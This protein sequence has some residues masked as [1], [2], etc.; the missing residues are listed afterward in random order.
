MLSPNE[1][2]LRRIAVPDRDKVEPDKPPETGQPVED[3]YPTQIP[4]PRGLV[5][6]AATEAAK[7]VH[8]VRKFKDR[9]EEAEYREELRRRTGVPFEPHERGLV[10]VKEAEMLSRV[11]LNSR[12]EVSQREV[13][14]RWSERMVESQGLTESPVGDDFDKVCADVLVMS[15]IEKRG[16][17]PEEMYRLDGIS[18]ERV[19]ALMKREIKGLD[20]A[21]PAT[22]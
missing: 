14:E 8:Q 12:E 20:G 9:F 15:E 5:E 6:R 13:V 4:L 22:G 10:W 7:Q 17:H 18:K 3:E 1:R 2:R 21:A 16:G 19:Q 11:P